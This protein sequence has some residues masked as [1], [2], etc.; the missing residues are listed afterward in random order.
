ME[1]EESEFI[2]AAE[3]DG[4]QRGDEMLRC[5]LIKQLLRVSN[6]RLIAK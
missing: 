4:G 5:Y 3:G 6:K 1:D 2:G